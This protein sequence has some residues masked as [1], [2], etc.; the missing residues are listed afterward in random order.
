M[1]SSWKL[2]FMGFHI[3]SYVSVFLLT[4]FILLCLQSLAYFFFIR[5]GFKITLVYWLRQTKHDFL[6]NSYWTRK[7]GI[8]L[9]KM[10][11]LLRSNKRWSW[12]YSLWS[13]QLYWQQIP[14]CTF[15][16]MD[17]H[18]I[19]VKGLPWYRCSKSSDYAWMKVRCFRS[20]L[21]LWTQ[22]LKTLFQWCHQ[23]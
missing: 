1:Q 5:I 13:F 3:S 10:T 16:Q 19:L 22:K 17:C 15:W 6:Q 23:K 4:H 12:N 11:T 2:F 7:Y 14:N 18:M 8:S 20:C 21:S 9:V